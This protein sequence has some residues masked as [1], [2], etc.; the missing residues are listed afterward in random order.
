MT[1]YQVI[2]LNE[3]EHLNGFWDGFVLQPMYRTN[4]GI[5]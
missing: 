3:R 2:A 1:W 5:A 4:L